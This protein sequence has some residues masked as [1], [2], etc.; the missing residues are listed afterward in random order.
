MVSLMNGLSAMGAGVASFAGTAGLEAQKA[1]LA[2]Q[3]AILADQLQGKRESAGRAQA[4]DIA[5]AAAEKQQTFEAGQNTLTRASQQSIAQ[6]RAGAELG[7]A[8]IS[9]AASKYSADMQ[10]GSVYAQI[11]ALAPGRAEEVLADKQKTAMAAVQTQNASDLRDAHAALEAETAKAAPDPTKIASLKS[12]VTSL[13]ASASTEAA[14]T[15]ASAAMYRT[16]MDSVT[17]Y[18]T[19]L[20]QAT[21]ALNTPGM[22]D[23]DR[24]AQKGLVADLK[25]QLTGAQRAL[26]YSSDLVRGRVAAAT[27]NPPPGVAPPPPSGVP[28]GARYSPSMKIWQAPDGQLFDAQGKPTTAPGAAPTIGGG[29]MN[30]GAGAAP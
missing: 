15:S 30:N 26:Q 19:Q 8:G 22:S 16:D 14:V 11:A 1:D 27:G 21:N 9:A 20:V 12:Q 3:Q 2:Q 13:E 24:A 28:A 17:H 7:A 25:V 4:G 29:F 18:N 6:T 23:T 5:A 10:S